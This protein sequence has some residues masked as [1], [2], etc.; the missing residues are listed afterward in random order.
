MYYCV[1]C[2]LVSVFC[3]F[4][5]CCLISFSETSPTCFS[6]TCCNVPRWGPAWCW[7]VP[8]HRLVVCVVT[9]QVCYYHDS[10]HS[11]VVGCPTP[12]VDSLCC[13]PTGVFLPWHSVVVGC[14]TPQVGSVCC[15]P[16]PVDVHCV[17]MSDPVYACRYHPVNVHGLM[18]SD[19]V[20]ACAYY[21]VSVYWSWMTFCAPLHAGVSW[22]TLCVYYTL[23]VFIVYSWMLLC[24]HVWIIPVSVHCLVMND[25]V[26]AT[27]ECSLY[28]HE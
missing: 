11:V 21:P 3:S 28:C 16:D 25:P 7:A 10:W 6:L 13:Y 5:H 20:C 1:G 26:C 27:C 23:W 14:C 9:P 2:P 8:P 12:Q 18:M 4:V 15:Y 24:M 19:P 17:M 22:M